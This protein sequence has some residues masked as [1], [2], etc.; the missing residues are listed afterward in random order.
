MM[1][2]PKLPLTI[3]KLAVCMYKVLIRA[4][5]CAKSVQLLVLL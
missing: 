5:K 1:M 4:R 2:S 3:L